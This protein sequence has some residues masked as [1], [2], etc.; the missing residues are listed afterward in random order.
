MSPMKK[1]L[2]TLIL[3]CLAFVLAACNGQAAQPT[4]GPGSYVSAD[5]TFTFSYPPEWVLVMIE[6]DNILDVSRFADTPDTV[7]IEVSVPMTFDDYSEAGLGTSVRDI[8]NAKAQL[9]QR[10]GPRVSNDVTIQ[11][12]D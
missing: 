12:A 10:F 11:T 1:T 8:V 7:Q 3:G 4:A 5:G 6:P 9:W 2:F